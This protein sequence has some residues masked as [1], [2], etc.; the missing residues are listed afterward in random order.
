MSSPSALSLGHPAASRCASKGSILERSPERV[1]PAVSSGCRDDLMTPRLAERA[2]TCMRH[3][4][5]RFDRDDLMTPRLAERAST[6][7]RHSP[8]RFDRDDL[9]TPRLAE[10]ASTCMRHSPVRFDRDDLMTPRLA[11]RA[12]TCMRHSPVSPKGHAV[13]ITR[14]FQGL[15]RHLFLHAW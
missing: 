9:M 3:S 11:E 7:M 6:C 1:S 15:G 4:P 5:V 12:S 10:L 8:V 14:G 2:S 13:A